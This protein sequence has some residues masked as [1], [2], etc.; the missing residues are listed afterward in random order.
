M[1]LFIS[2]NCVSSSPHHHFKTVAGVR[3]TAEAPQYRNHTWPGHHKVICLWFVAF[4]IWWPV[5]SHFEVI[6]E[7]HRYSDCWTSGWV[8]ITENHQDKGVI[9]LRCVA[10]MFGQVN[11]QRGSYP[12][13]PVPIWDRRSLP[14][15]VH[16]KL[17]TKA[18]PKPV[19]DSAD[20]STVREA[21]KQQLK[22]PQTPILFWPSNILAMAVISW[23]GLSFEE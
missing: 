2:K 13:G 6:R 7:V 21:Q 10:T 22:Q 3:R 4:V 11:C 17:S 16:C 19:C 14:S 1:A 5:P 20:A 15:C 9:I 18:R 12:I 8:G 23:E